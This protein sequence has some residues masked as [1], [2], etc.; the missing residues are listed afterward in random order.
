MS[1]KLVTD[2][3]FSVPQLFAFL[4]ATI[5]NYINPIIF[6]NQGFVPRFDMRNIYVGCKDNDFS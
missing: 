6:I 1:H 2:D 4:R 5:L 3:G